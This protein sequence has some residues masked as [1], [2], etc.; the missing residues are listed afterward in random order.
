MPSEGLSGSKP[1]NQ[2]TIAVRFRMPSWSLPAPAFMIRTSSGE[3]LR[4]ASFM[5][6][7]RF[8]FSRA[9]SGCR[10]LPASRLSELHGARLRDQIEGDH[11][12]YLSLLLK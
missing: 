1:V 3:I 12:L 8:V 7:S 10:G 2:P 4:H 11:G 6:R 9:A 5:F